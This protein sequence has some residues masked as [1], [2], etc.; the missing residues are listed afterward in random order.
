MGSGGTSVG[1]GSRGMRILKSMAWSL[2]K[3]ESS[4][5]GDSGSTD[6]DEGGKQGGG[7]TR[8]RSGEGGGVGYNASPD[9]GIGAGQRDM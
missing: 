9:Q 8:S 7:T 6:I 1:L 5:G 3:G 4:G 2:S